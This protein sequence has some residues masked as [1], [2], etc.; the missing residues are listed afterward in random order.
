MRTIP[1]HLALVGWPVRH[2]LSP[3]LWEGM[4]AR[5]GIPIV[6]VQYPVPPDDV[7][8]WSLL[9]RSELAGFNV[10][11]PFKERA[12]ARCARLAPIAARIGAVNTVIRDGEE[13]TGHSTDGYGFTRA[14]LAA[15]EPIRGRT[16]A[17]LGTGG[18]GR[19]VARALT[20]AGAA[21]TLVTRGLDRIPPGC[22]GL[23][24]IGWERLA[25]AGPFDIVV[26]ATPIGRGVATAAAPDIP[27]DHW[28]RG[29]VAIDLN[30]T[31][32]VTA[33]LREARAA[34]ART[35]NGLGMLV[36]QACMAAALVI[37]GDAAAAESYEE[38]FWA[39]AREVG[40]P[41]DLS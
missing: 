3:R 40:V 13:W 19:A 27:Y 29:A 37:E 39:V 30:Y 15:D 17:V 21:V 14:L 23:E 10:T 33:F 5:R 20:D 25:D 31:P 16:A 35:L 24:L 38:D 11:A 41:V 7:D 6:Y 2:S 1:L 18:A 9:W 22:E 36:H 32:P 34:G 26:N 4:G 12:S 28:C 8:A